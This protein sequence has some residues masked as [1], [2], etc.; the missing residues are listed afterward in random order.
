MSTKENTK[1]YKNLDGFGGLDTSSP[2]GEGRIVALKNFK[3]LADGSVVKRGGFKLLASFENEIR[4]EIAYVEDGEEIILFAVGNKLC[5]VSVETGE[6]LSAECFRKTEGKI[7]FFEFRGVLYAIEDGVFYQYKGKATVSQIKAYAPLF[8]YSE[9]YNSYKCKYVE[10]LNMLSPTIRLQFVC[11]GY[12]F[13]FLLS[14]IKLESVDAM[15]INGRI[16]DKDLYELEEDGLTIFCGN[17]INAEVG[18][19]VTVYATVYGGAN[20]SSDLE[21]CNKA[22]VFDSF[23]D[24]RV[25]LYGGNNENRFYVTEPVDKTELSDQTEAYGEEIL[26][27]YLPKGEGIRFGGMEKIN[28]MCRFYDRMLIFTKQRVFAT[29]DLSEKKDGQGIVLDVRSYTVGC[30]SDNAVRQIDGVT[31][32]SVSYGGIYKWDLDRNFNEEFVIKKMSK[33]ID[34][35]ISKP[36]FENARVCYNR[37]DEEVWF[38]LYDTGEVLVYNTSLKLWYTYTGIFAQ[39]FIETSMGIAFV[40]GKDVYIFDGGE[41]DL[42][43][44]GVRHIEA[45]LES[46]F[47]CFTSPKSKKH[48]SG[49]YLTCELDGGSITATL[50]DGEILDVST[51]EGN[52]PIEFFDLRIRSPRTNK[53]KFKLSAGGLSKQ[54]I[55]GVNLLTD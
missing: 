11:D 10:P 12:T 3:Q 14:K 47:W 55:Y 24:S 6:M 54:R 15:Y 38:A 5:K 22:S 39:R 32:I 29:E 4:G 37:N 27:L 7:C 1:S 16:I 44:D 25:F 19:T 26:P 52:E 23:S 30:S 35:L 2:I 49:L 51:L 33:E 17:R 13:P 36:F 40:D 48:L 41:C 34:S 8:T 50:D 18:E 42:T 21:S 31:P 20:R 45:Y 28:A 53:V 46:A 43:K 9:N